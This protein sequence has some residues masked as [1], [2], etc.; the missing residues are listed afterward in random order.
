MYHNK[1]H[2]VLSCPPVISRAP[3]LSLSLAAVNPGWFSRMVLLFWCWLTQVVLEKRPLNESSSSISSSSS[4][5]S[6]LVMFGAVS[7]Q[8]LTCL[9]LLTIHVSVQI[10]KPFYC[11]PVCLC[12]RQ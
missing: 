8:T 6:S 5:S 1:I 9:Y 12:R 11:V 10:E 3:G 7:Y 4:S 2:A